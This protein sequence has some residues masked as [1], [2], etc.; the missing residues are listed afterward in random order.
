MAVDNCKVITG[1]SNVCGDLLQGS[2]V[3]KDIYVGY[4][5]QLSIRFP[6]IQTAPI[7]SISWLSYQGLVKF[8][9]QQF[10]NEASYELAKAGGGTLSYLHKLTIR[11]MNL[12]TQDDV[13][14]QRLTQAQNMF[15]IIEDANEQLF[16]FGASRGM[17]ADAGAIKSFG[18]N[19]GEDV[20][21]SV[22]LSGNEKTLPLRFLVSDYTTTIAYLENSIR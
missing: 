22:S 4:T 1:I 5:T 2:G 12:S 16:I 21:S 13:E 7:S 6:L 18:K 11:V 9:G 14:L 19:A 15:A 8:S 17:Q 3:G 20:I 10:S